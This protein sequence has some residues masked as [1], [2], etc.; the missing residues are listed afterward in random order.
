MGYAQTG[1]FKQNLAAGQYSPNIKSRSSAMGLASAPA[2]GPKMPYAPVQNSHGISTTTPQAK[3][4]SI[5]QQRLQSRGIAPPA[6]QQ[7]P[8]DVSTFT[9]QQLAQAFRDQQVSGDRSS[10]SVYGAQANKMFSDPTNGQMNKR[11]F[12][13]AYSGFRTPASVQPYRGTQSN[14]GFVGQAQAPVQAAPV[15]PKYTPYSGPSN[16]RGYTNAFANTSGYPAGFIP[17]KG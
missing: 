5:E 8:A 12:V 3:P 11:N 7:L 13:Q 10:N 14:R 16:Q 6:P 2:A 4:P 1:N 9:P 17:F 15:A